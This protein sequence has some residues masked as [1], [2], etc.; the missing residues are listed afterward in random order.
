MNVIFDY[1]SSFGSIKQLR[2]F[3]VLNSA[4]CRSGQKVAVALQVWRAMRS[5]GAIVNIIINIYSLW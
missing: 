4:M 3:V 1:I 5:I 2:G